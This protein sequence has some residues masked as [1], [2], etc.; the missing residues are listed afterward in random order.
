[1]NEPMRLEGK[2]AVLRRTFDQSF[3]VPPPETSLDVEDLLRIRVAGDPYAIRLR[4]IAGIV[5][6]RKV[7]PIPGG[8]RDLLGSAGIRGGIVPVFALAML[9]GYDQAADV[10]PWMVLCR[11]EDPIAL[12]FPEFEGY[13]GVSKSSI[14]LDGNLRA[15]RQHVNEIACIEAERRPV[16]SIPLIVATIRNRAGQTRPRSTAQ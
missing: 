15:A 9:L 12:A 10:L 1:M 6:R 8:T 2:T 7:V 4:D 14:H 13:A 3:A 11:S 16:I 5:A